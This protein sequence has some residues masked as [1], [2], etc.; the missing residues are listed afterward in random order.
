MLNKIKVYSIIAIIIILIINLIL[1][2]P[3]WALILLC[4]YFVIVDIKEDRK[5]KNEDS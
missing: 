2:L 5:R 1:L 3:T 4:I